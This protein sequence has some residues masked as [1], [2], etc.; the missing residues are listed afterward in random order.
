MGGEVG[1]GGHNG[2]GN[3]GGNGKRRLHPNQLAALKAHQ[4]APWTKENAP[5]VHRPKNYVPPSAIMAR[6]FADSKFR[7][8]WEAHIR[9]VVEQ[10]SDRDF[11]QLTKELRQAL[12]GDKLHVEQ[13]ETHEW[14]TGPEAV[15]AEERDPIPAAL[16]TN[17]LPQ[18][19]G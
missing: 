14:E 15:D 9:V 18:R 4:H 17:R 7:Q 16:G 8:A 13:K 2:N 6:L 1:S 10:G 12:E 11:V 19:E 5:R 3:G